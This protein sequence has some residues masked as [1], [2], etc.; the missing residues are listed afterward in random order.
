MGVIV[1]PM[2][3]GLGIFLGSIVIG[4][5]LLYLKTRDQWRWRTIVK[6]F[7]ASVVILVVLSIATYFAIDAYDRWADRPNV[8]TSLKGI[9]IG[10]KF[11]DVVFRHGEFEK[12]EAESRQKYLDEEKHV[13][14]DLRVTVGVRKGIVEDVSYLCDQ[15]R[16]DYSEVN[17]ISCN[18][19]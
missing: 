8:V 4:V 12:L 11:S 14:G 16:T 19:S 18:N 15:E 17:R 6:R 2:S 3:T 1:C 7:F 9:S 10:D 13:Q 5:V